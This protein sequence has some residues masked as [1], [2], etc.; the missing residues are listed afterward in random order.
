MFIPKNDNEIMEAMAKSLSD[1]NFMNFE[2]I[3]SNNENKIVSEH[4]K[5]LISIADE[6]DRTGFSKQAS[7]IDNIVQNMIKTSVDGGDASNFMVSE[8]LPEV[9]KPEKSVKQIRDDYVPN[10]DHISDHTLQDIFWSFSITTQRDLGKAIN[11]KTGTWSDFI[12]QLRKHPKMIEWM[13]KKYNSPAPA[14][15]PASEICSVCKKE[16]DIELWKS[17][18]G[19]KEICNNCMLLRQRR[20]NNRWYRSDA[21]ANVQKQLGFTGKVIDGKW[22]PKTAKAWNAYMQNNNIVGDYAQKADP[23]GMTYKNLNEK[24]IWAINNF[25]SQATVKKVQNTIGKGMEKGVGYV[26]NK[27]TNKPISNRP[28]QQTRIPGMETRPKPA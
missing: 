11:F 27:L 8:P 10:F 28:I 7:Q 19:G 13:L 6:M 21:V 5:K 25:G 26:K 17:Q 1:D 15:A 2:K 22:G 24:L 12:K 14:P 3:A 18:P 4:L 23:N 16:M 20:L 9:R